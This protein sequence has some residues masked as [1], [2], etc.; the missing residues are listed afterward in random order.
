VILLQRWYTRDVPGPALLMV[1]G[2]AV[3]LVGVFFA[4][5]LFPDETSIVCLF[6]AALATED[7]LKRI[8]DWNRRAIVEEGQRPSSVNRRTTTLVLAMF[9]GATLGFSVLSLVLPL[10]Q[11]EVLFHHQLTGIEAARFP[12][13]DFGAPVPLFVINLS[14]FLFFFVIAIPFQHGGVML[15]VA[16][17]ASVWGA[18]FGVVARRWAAADGPSMLLAYVRV[19]GATIPHMVFEA[20]AYLCAGMAGVFLSKALVKHSLDSDIFLSV[21]RSVAAMMLVG[22]GLVACGALWEG[23]VTPQLVAWFSGNPGG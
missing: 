20:A 21:A 19:M 5:W 15:A 6:L 14:V 23:L 13:L 16:W 1:E 8:L 12:D 22:V 4:A 3:V 11:V 10:G 7:S 9:G 18:V 17:N 2:L